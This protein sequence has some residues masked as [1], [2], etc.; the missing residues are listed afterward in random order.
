MSKLN[1][2][3]YRILEALE[4]NGRLPVTRLAA[5][6]GVSVS[7]C[8]QRVRRL[9]QSGII[10][11]YVAEIALEK[12]QNVQIVLA[13][14]VLSKHNR[15]AYSLFER[16]IKEI[17]EVV[18]CYEVAGQFDYHLKFVVTDMERYNHILETLLDASM[19]IEK[20]F[21]YV[22]TRTAK[23]SRMLSVRDLIKET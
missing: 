10:R 13:Q 12:L 8:W 1:R 3:D 20:Y 16:R 22:V 11:R 4:E 9:E 15:P 21:T 6:V 14:I 19:G 7:P 17:A 5:M 2:I 23:N 18:E